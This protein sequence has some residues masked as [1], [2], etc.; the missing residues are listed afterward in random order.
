M[1]GQGGALVWLAMSDDF[2]RRKY[3]ACLS[4][5]EH[6]RRFARSIGS[7]LHEFAG[8]ELCYD[9]KTVAGS[10][11]TTAINAREALEKGRAYL[12]VVTRASVDARWVREEWQQASE[13]AARERLFRTLLLVSSDVETD[14]IPTELQGAPRIEL[15]AEA[16][17]GDAA[18]ARLLSSL[19]VS[20]PSPTSDDVYVTRSWRDDERVCDFADRACAEIGKRFRLIG[21]SPREDYDLERIASIM[22]SCGAYVA[23]IPPREPSRLKFMLPEVA[24]ARSC[25]LPTVVFADKEV[26][27]HP[28]ES[29]RT[30]DGT[31]V[32]LDGAIAVDMKGVGLNDET[33]RLLR[34]ETGDLKERY[35][36]PSNPYTVFFASEAVPDRIRQAINSVVFGV[37]G[38]KCVFPKDIQAEG[39]DDVQKRLA[40]AIR[41]A[42][43][44]IADVTSESTETWIQAGIARG[45]SRRLTLLTRDAAA[46]IPF[47][48]GNMQPTPYA[49]DVERLGLVHRIVFDHRRRF[50]N[51]EVTR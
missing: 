40:D 22:A 48:F 33:E 7:W 44:V 29:L 10:R 32:A 16:P 12:L 4:H 3:G 34:R 25:G 9:E 6:D 14:R 26:L 27:N 1:A 42:V 13:E 37:T 18:A 41:G 35:R 30:L 43:A 11:T 39:R 2:H 5:S 19:Y 49:T 17:L 50:M 46:K 38:R 45:A 31:T 8:L 36:K 20:D 23:L 28:P 51:L 21:D 47:S 24:I 15:P